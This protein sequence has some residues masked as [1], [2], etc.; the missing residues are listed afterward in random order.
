MVKTLI[1]YP[2]SYL[3][4]ATSP[5]YSPSHP[6]R[7]SDIAAPSG[8]PIVI[9]GTVIGLVGMTGAAD[10]YHCHIQ[11]WIGNVANTR[12]PGPYA[13]QPGTVVNTG[14]ASEWGNFVTIDV[15]GVNVTYAHLS[16][17]NVQ[18]GQ[19]VGGQMHDVVT[20]DFIKG[21]FRNYWGVNATEENLEA[22]RGT[23]TLDMESAFR[24]SPQ[25]L[26]WKQKIDS[27]LAGDNIKVD[28]DA[29][30]KYVSENLK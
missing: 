23:L 2:V 11:A 28:K 29:V 3:Y 10:G 30:V 1:D 26:A 7:G 24:N 5:P 14:T 8:T 16:Q 13:F 4:G 22:W 15:N 18:T 19:K 21:M 9:A 20:D 17:V 6:H 25:N 12:D 27:A